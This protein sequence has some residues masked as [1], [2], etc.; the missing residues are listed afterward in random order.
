M[1]EGYQIL[2]GDT[3]HN[4]Y[5]HYVQDPPLSQIMAWASTY[6]DFYT[7]AYYTPAFRS[8]PPKAGLSQR[9]EGIEGGH[10]TEALPEQQSEWRGIHLESWK[11]PAAMAREWAEVQ[12]VTA[13]WDRPGEFVTFPG[14][15]WQ[16]NGRWGD[17]N[18]IHRFEGHPIQRVD[19]LPELYQRLQS[20]QAIAIPHHTAYRVGQRAPT[21]SACDDRISPFAEIYSIHGCSETDEEW[22]G[23]RHNSHMGPGVGGGTYQEAL[24]RGL[25]LGAICST[26]NWTNMPGQWGQGLMA[27]V[28]RELT[29]E[30]LWEAFLAR[31]VYGVTGD[32]IELAFTCNGAPMGSTL[33]HAPRRDI[34][35]AVRGSDAI[36]RIE[37]L[38]NGKVMATHCHQGTWDLPAPGTRARFKLRVEAGWGPRL[39]EVPL[40][41]KKWEGVL[42]VSGGRMLAW[43]P[44]WISREQGI[45]RLE[46]DSA[47]FALVSRQAYV[48]RE[49][50]GATLFEFEADP[51]AELV[52]RLNGL[53]LRDPVQAYA[54]GSR[55]LWYR[56]ECVRLVRETTGVEPA[57]AGRGDVYYQ[58]APKAKVHRAVPERAYTATVELTDEEPLEHETHYRVR[59]EQRN[60]QRAWSSPIWIGAPSS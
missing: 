57:D 19:T 40:G 12:S 36:D 4:T 37:I 33:G 41:D 52:L 38:R 54:A 34:R 3:H 49:M 15:E 31:R 51:G 24:D 45:P 44:C 10:L 28:A 21:W 39:G 30:S 32:R 9:V 5:Q 14:Y 11:E 46:R 26:D 59:V 1:W 29:R 13:D 43:E 23:L 35:V 56:D 20:L 17:H 7:G 55:L 42:S 22:I 16:G 2:W 27:C 47:R 6:L 8:V 25:H 60:G 50:Q 18:V 53:E 58:L 48:P